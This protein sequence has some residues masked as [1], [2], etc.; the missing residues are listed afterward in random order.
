[1]AIPADAMTPSVPH[2]AAHHHG[3]HHSI[4][5]FGSFTSSSSS[6]VAFGSASTSSYIPSSSVRSGGGDWQD[7]V[8]EE[9]G[10]MDG[11][12]MDDDTFAYGSRASSLYK[13]L[14]AVTGNSASSAG[15]FLN[16]AVASKSTSLERRREE[17]MY[18]MDMD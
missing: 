5:S 1:M 13:R 9:N 12:D 15:G 8:E 3:H 4:S 6:F 10:D 16:T 7:K 17:Y 14:A 2:V 18:D 11:M